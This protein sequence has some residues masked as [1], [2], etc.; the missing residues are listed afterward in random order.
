MQSRWN[1]HLARKGA[2]GYFL[3]TLDK[4]INSGNY[5][6]E[7]IKA[8]FSAVIKTKLWELYKNDICAHKSFVCATFKG[9]RNKWVL[10]EN[11]NIV[12]IPLNGLNKEEIWT[13]FPNLGTVVGEDKIIIH[14]TDNKDALFIDETFELDAPLLQRLLENADKNNPKLLCDWI[15]N[16]SENLKNSCEAVINSLPIFEI[17][18]KNGIKWRSWNECRSLIEQQQLYKVSDGEYLQH[19]F[20]LLCAGGFGLFSCRLKNGQIHSEDFPEFSDE[21][22][23]EKLSYVNFAEVKYDKKRKELI[24]WFMLKCDINLLELVKESLSKLDFS[25]WNDIEIENLLSEFYKLDK[26]RTV[27]ILCR[28]KIHKRLNINERISVTNNTFLE[29]N[30]ITIDEDKCSSK[31]LFKECQNCLQEILST[32]NIVNRFDDDSPVL[33]AQNA[34]FDDNRLLKWKHVVE[35]ILQHNEPWQFTSL[36][37][38]AHACEGGSAIPQGGFETM[39]Q[40]PLFEI[41]NEHVCPNKIL[42][43]EGLEEIIKDFTPPGFF[44]KHQ[45]PENYQGEKILKRLFE[46]EKFVLEEITKQMFERGYVL[47]LEVENISSDD[48][49][50]IVNTMK[51]FDLFH[52]ARVIYKIITTLPE[53]TVSRD[54]FNSSLRKLF[55]PFSL[56]NIELRKNVLKYLESVHLEKDKEYVIHK[57]YMKQFIKEGALK[58]FFDSINLPNE[59]EEWKS[60]NNLTWSIGNDGLQSCFKLKRDYA[61]V[62]APQNTIE[63]KKYWRTQDT[64]ITSFDT[65]TDNPEKI[66]EY[67]KH[68]EQYESYILLA[69]SFIEIVCPNDDVVKKHLS[70]RAGYNYFS[71]KNFP[72][73]QNNKC[74]PRFKICIQEN[75]S[76]DKTAPALTGKIFSYNPLEVE[77]ME[78]FVDRVS[79]DKLILCLPSKKIVGEEFI[80]KFCATLRCISETGLG[81]KLNTN[82]FQR[83]LLN[84]E[85]NSIQL[86]P[87][88][89]TLLRE[90]E[91]RLYLLGCQHKRLFKMIIKGF[92]EAKRTEAHAEYMY[93]GDQSKDGKKSL[94]ARYRIAAASRRKTEKK[95]QA[96]IEN[97]QCAEELLI[98]ATTKK[99]RIN[100]YSNKSTFLE[101][102]QNADDALVE[103]KSRE[104]VNKNEKCFCLKY[105]EKTNCLIIY[106]WGRYINRSLENDIEATGYDSDLYKMLSWNI[107]DKDTISKTENINTTGC[108]G[109]GFKSIFLLC[110]RPLIKSDTLA[111]RVRGSFLPLKDRDSAKLHTESILETI[112][113][114]YKPT[115]FILDELSINSEKVTTLI[116]NFWEIAPYLIYTSFVIEAIETPNGRIEQNIVYSSQN[117]KW[118]IATNNNKKYFIVPQIG[119]EAPASWIFNINQSGFIECPKIIKRL[120]ITVP[121]QETSSIRCIVNAKWKTDPGRARIRLTIKNRVIAQEAANYLKE[122]LYELINETDE[123]K[124]KNFCNRLQLRDSLK[125]YEFWESF[126]KIIWDNSMLDSLTDWDDVIN[127]ND[128]SKTDII[129]ALLWDKDFGAIRQLLD[130]NEFNVPSYV[131]GKYQVLISPVNV[132]F[133]LDENLDKSFMKHCLKWNEWQNEIP[134][135]IVSHKIGIFMINKLNVNQTRTNKDKIR[136][137]TLVNILE[138]QIGVNK[139]VTPEL[140]T[141]LGAVLNK[142]FKKVHFTDNDNEWKTIQEFISDLSFQCV[143]KEYHSVKD[144]IVVGHKVEG[145]LDIKEDERKRA[146]FAPDSHH[147]HENYN[148]YEAIEFFCLCRVKLSA[149]VEVLTNWIKSIGEGDKRKIEVFR[150]FYEEGELVIPLARNLG[151]SWLQQHE[152]SEILNN[153]NDLQNNICRLF[154]Y[155]TEKGKIEFNSSHT[156]QTPLAPFLPEHTRKENFKKISNWWKA[157]GKSEIEG[158]NLDL[159]GSMSPFPLY[160]LGDDKYDNCIEN[161]RKNWIILFIH[162]AM[163]TKGWYGLG[164]SREFIQFL[165][166]KKYLNTFANSKSTAEDFCNI[167]DRFLGDN[168]GEIQYYHHMRQYIT[169][170][171]SSKHLETI[172]HWLRESEK[173]D[174][175]DRTFSADIPTFAGTGIGAPSFVRSFGIGQHFII[176]ELIRCGLVKS[177]NA[178][179]WAYVPNKAVCDFCSSYLGITFSDNENHLDSSRIINKGIEKLAELCELSDTTFD[180]SFDIP[181]Y[182]LANNSKKLSEIGISQGIAF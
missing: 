113:T 85:I 62:L 98:K 39:R 81:I 40:T 72:E 100:G 47:G 67:L 178:K 96:L 116:N 74:W 4:F 41:N 106:H 13:V 84:A 94:S 28:L 155:A 34:I 142:E 52:I 63:Q 71:Q 69:T 24:K 167:L 33:G 60:V 88:R 153:L 86:R 166:D 143:D 6:S 18:N 11:K 157:C 51:D 105:S 15:D 124:W 44:T 174:Y 45:V 38:H 87:I 5:T 48:L 182:I 172:L 3:E 7:Q 111:C 169:F 99:I 114:N 10:K 152:E 9:G 132:K 56:K 12:R 97:D 37:F 129:K 128:K 140:A 160:W 95:L 83:R 75:T 1:S 43:I 32:F 115:F 2:L 78:S 170:Y 156:L 92:H 118:K 68:F 14:D 58:S 108:F 138:K 136:E 163:F 134:D 179:N 171:A 8:L 154:E 55:V 107:S 66:I 122:A 147:L 90:S 149:D 110:K 144:V 25:D 161:Q 180:N 27:D 54:D 49:F 119:T 65:K 126:W 91:H 82:L 159:Y 165:D 35:W 127:E 177:P 146:A 80:E 162:T 59:D 73:L 109:H 53:E 17:Q 137:L 173:T 123:L 125:P 176:R 61:D 19:G 23:K 16:L 101:L 26:S 148:S 20:R 181:L 135:G 141:Q 168:T 112:D 120:W 121:T 50:K 77:N 133:Y 36:I 93:S 102:F 31:N 46:D 103:R 104:Q 131:D 175:W 89:D 29:N 42:H 117:N 76:S 22:F 30:K 164:N 79:D 145:N 130:S 158:Y 151:L 70:R 139:Y 21:V 150:Y 64:E 57:L